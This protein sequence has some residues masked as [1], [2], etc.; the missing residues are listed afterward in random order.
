MA[1]VSKTDFVGEIRI[2]QANLDNT[3]LQ[4]YIDRVVEDRLRDLM[5]DKL[6]NEYLADLDGSGDPQTQKFIDLV[7]GKTYEDCNGYEVI[8]LGLKRMLRYFIFADYKE[9]NIY[10][11]TTIGTVRQNSDTSVTASWY[12]V[13][14]EVK[15]FYD[16]G[17][18][19]YYDAIKYILNDIDT[20]F[21]DQ[22]DFTYKK[23]TK[24][25]KLKTVTA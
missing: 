11:D 5:G 9:N 4:T 16:K 25:S 13:S 6:Y 23:I 20:Y 14:N 12:N 17:V 24:I 1:I 18:V 10:E 3:E 21:T 2:A 15:R 7:D 22:C 19:L 8:Y